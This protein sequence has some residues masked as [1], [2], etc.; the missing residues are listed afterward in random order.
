MEA[1]QKRNETWLAKKPVIRDSHIF[2]RAEVAM[3]SLFPEVTS[4]IQKW[5]INADGFH[6]ILVANA[7]VDWL[8]MMTS[9]T[10]FHPSRRHLARCVLAESIFCVLRYRQYG[11]I[12]C[13]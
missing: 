13:N 8:R 6:S 1:I 4:K 12:E 3:G 5:N 10:S 2:N 11:S 7:R 9:P